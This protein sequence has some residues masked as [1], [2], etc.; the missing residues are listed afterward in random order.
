M[1]IFDRKVTDKD[2]DLEVTPMEWDEEESKNEGGGQR[3]DT[4]ASDE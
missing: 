1:S 3:T 4:L 2:D